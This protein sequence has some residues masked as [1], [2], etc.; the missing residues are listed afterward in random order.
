MPEDTTSGLDTRN[1]NEFKKD[2]IELVRVGSGINK[3]YSRLS[4]DIDKYITQ[5]KKIIDLFNKKYKNLEIKLEKTTEELK[6]R[7]FIKEKSVKD[8]FINAA[9][10]LE[11]PNNLSLEDYEKGLVELKYVEDIANEK[12]PEFNLCAHYAV[13]SCVKDINIYE[14]LI[15]MGFVERPFLNKV[16]EFFKKFNP[17]MEE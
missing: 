3:E 4:K 14:M 13:K 15:G 17:R 11:D 12:T 10:T 16:R 7:I 1:L 5:F 9:S 2:F 6:L 8:V